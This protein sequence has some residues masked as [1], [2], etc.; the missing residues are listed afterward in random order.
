MTLDDTPSL[1]C[2]QARMVDQLATEELAYPSLL[3]MENAALNATAAILDYLDDII[4]IDPDQARIGVLCGG[5]SNG[6]DGYA[7]ARQLSTWAVDVDILAASDPAKLTGDPA[8]NHTIC[9]RLGL[10]I[11]VLAETTAMEQHRQSLAECDLIIDALLGTG[12]TGQVR[13]PLASLIQ[14]VNGLQGPHIVAIDLPSGMDGD[15]GDASHAT[16]R[17]DLTITFV[18]PKVGFAAAG[19]ADYTG[20]ILVAD[21]GTPESLLHR[22]LRET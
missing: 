18:A 9:Q 2:Q 11:E 13:E 8:I 5:G 1:T 6:G 14:M 20:R 12:F 10:P 16:I 22:V 7:I 15:T 17:A 3:L 21:I 19:A 4:Q